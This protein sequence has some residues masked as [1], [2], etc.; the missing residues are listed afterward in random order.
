MASTGSSPPIP[1]RT[2][3]GAS[4][5]SRQQRRWIGPRVLVVPGRRAHRRVPRGRP[6]RHR[7]AHRRPDRPDRRTQSRPLSRRGFEQRGRVARD[8]RSGQRFPRPRSMGPRGVPVSAR[9]TWPS[10]APMTLLVQSRDQRTT[11]VLEVDDASGRTTIVRE[12]HD[13]DWIELVLG[14]PLER[15]TDG[16]SPRSMP[17]T[18]ASGDRGTT[19]DTAGT[20]GPRRSSGRSDGVLITASPDPRETH[21]Y[22]VPSRRRGSR[23]LT[24]A[25][26]VHGG[27]RGRRHPGRRL[28]HPRP[29]SARRSRCGCGSRV[30]R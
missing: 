22:R 6:S 4:R 5:S 17:T 19:R 30:G 18:R 14:S 23:Q 7:L 24:T 12:D 2:C 21:V 27:G 25:P 9:V 11:Q 26:G 20:A 13:Q 10:T 16:S 15:P 8:L 28:A 1:T 29:R 3:L